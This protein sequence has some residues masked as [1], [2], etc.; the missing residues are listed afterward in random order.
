MQV[1]AHCRLIS[2]KAGSIGPLGKLILG[3]FP[4]GQLSDREIEEAQETR[5]IHWEQIRNVC[6]KDILK[7]GLYQIICPPVVIHFA[8]VQSR[9]SSASV[10]P[11]EL[12]S[13]RQLLLRLQTPQ[14]LGCASE[15]TVEDVL[16][17][18]PRRQ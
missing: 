12:T 6:P 2:C 17:G 14:I 11:F 18:N 10:V 7:D 5:I 3:N 9:I 15:S 1:L 8:A 4:T 13:K 16:E